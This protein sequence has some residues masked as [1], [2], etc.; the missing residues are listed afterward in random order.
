MSCYFHGSNRNQQHLFITIAS[1]ILVIV[2][3]LMINESIQIEKKSSKNFKILY[4]FHFNLS[5]GFLLC[6][7]KR[8]NLKC[9]EALEVSLIS[10]T[11][12]DEILN[13]FNIY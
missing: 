3:I 5:F 8:K 10:N 4:N 13:N 9:V 1:K 2:S 11:E 12:Y 7:W 6:K